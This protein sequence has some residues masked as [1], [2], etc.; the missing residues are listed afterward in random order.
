VTGPPR[1]YS[2]YSDLS[3]R[4]SDRSDQRVK[5]NMKSNMKSLFYICK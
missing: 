3:D 5:S 4:R 1:K 2:R